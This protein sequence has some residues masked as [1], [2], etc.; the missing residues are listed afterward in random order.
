MPLARLAPAEH[1][2]WLAGIVNSARVQMTRRGRMMVVTID[3]GTAQV[4]LTV[5]NELFEQHRDK[6]KEDNLLIVQGKVQVD[7]FSGGFRVTAD[8]VL[9]LAELRCRYA[10]RLR[11]ALNGQADAQQLRELL[12]PYRAAAGEGACPV[13]VHYESAR[14]AC[15]VVLGDSWRVR[16]ESPLIERLSEWLTPENVQLVYAEAA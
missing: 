11:I 7:N 6:L 12:S 16:P 10:A 14:A 1:R 15:D 4:E 9:D 13:L 8:D 3:D 2:V 5:F